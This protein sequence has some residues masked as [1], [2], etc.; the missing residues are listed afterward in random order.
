MEGTTPAKSVT[1]R[2]R[3]KLVSQLKYLVSGWV[4]V[5][6]WLH[7]SLVVYVSKT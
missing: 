7:D 2:D 4:V 6:P 1:K 5:L 3:E